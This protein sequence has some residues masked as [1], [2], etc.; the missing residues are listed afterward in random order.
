MTAFTGSGMVLNKR[1][2]M[3]KMELTNILKLHARW[4]D[5]ENDGVKADLQGTNLQGINLHG[6]NLRG[7]N[8]QRANLQKTSL[9]GA[10][11]RG[12]DLLR[13]DLI[14]ADLRG[15]DLRWADLRDANLRGAN[16][17][18]ANLYEANLQGANLEKANLY[19]ANLDY[20]C[21]PLWCGSKNV[22]VDVNIARQLAAHF[23]ALDCPDLDYQKAK[24][25]ILSFA[26]LSHRAV[27]LGLSMPSGCSPR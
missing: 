3:E 25:V 27:E 9:E 17:E 19:E 11:L 26:T 18:K 6:T 7:A 23:C 1:R 22:K 13:A 5:G 2:K 15:A 4:L 12:A 14:R 8:L 24:E 21:W 16:L 10:D 20:A